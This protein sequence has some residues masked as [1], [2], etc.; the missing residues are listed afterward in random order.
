L[1]DPDLRKINSA[2]SMGIKIG[3]GAVRIEIC[4]EGSCTGK[5]SK[6]QRRNM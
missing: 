1:L 3:A 6:M 2:G 4:T 5:G